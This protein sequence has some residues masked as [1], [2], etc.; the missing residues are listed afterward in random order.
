MKIKELP[1][2]DR[3][4]EK[5]KELGAESLT[6]RELIA[7]LLRTGNKNN[8]SALDLA[9]SILQQSNFSLTTLFN[10]PFEQITTIKGIGETKAITLMAVFEL[11]KRMLREQLKPREIPFTNPELV[12]DY[13][14]LDIQQLKVEEFRILTLTN[15]NT[16][17]NS[18]TIT[19]GIADGTMIHPRE[20]FNIAIKDSA[21]SIILV[22]NHPSGNLKPSREDLSITKKIVESGNILG[23]PVL[24]HLIISSKG[25]LS[26]KEEDYL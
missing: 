10:T 25:Y 17:I 7:I 2:E 26:F 24:D 9:H 18:H 22:H 8:G 16:L 14:K 19:K 3:P 4:R 6:N 1:T 23:I 21:S 13:L 15:A 12:Y 11:S 20:I 5:L